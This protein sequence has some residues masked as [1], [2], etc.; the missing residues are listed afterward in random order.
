MTLDT[1]TRVLLAEACRIIANAGLAEDILG[2]V[3]LRT[4]DGI[5][6]RCRGPQENGLLFTTPDDIHEVASGVEL[7]SGYQAPNELPIHSEVMR[8]R[9]DVKVVVH[10]HAPFVIAA[11]L[12]GIELRPVVGAYNMPAM[13]MAAEGIPT[14]PRSVLINTDELGREVA[15]ALGDSSVLVLRGHGVVTVGE[16]VEQAVV[17]AINLEILARM[18][19]H[20]SSRGPIG[21]EV[22]PEEQALMPDLGAGFNDGFVWRYQQSRL[23]LSGLALA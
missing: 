21:Y 1:G 5:A 19:V 23:R 22:S 12:A 4:D 11:D 18:L 8:A 7:E 13:R 10:A 15:A 2:H 3:S 16:T 20:A 14:Y 6:I 17:R 9:S